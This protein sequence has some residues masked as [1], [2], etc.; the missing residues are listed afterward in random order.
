M[1]RHAITVD[2]EDWYQSTIDARADL[3]D[4]FR[5]STDKV[6]ESFAARGVRGTFFCLGLAAQ[7]APAVIRAI[8]DAGHEVQSHG[9]GHVEV[10]KLTEDQFRQDL[11]RARKLLED[12]IGAKVYGY[13]AP[14]FSIDERT[15]WAH[16]VLA[17]THHRY[18]S[19]I[20]PIKMPRYGVDGY[21]PQPRIIQTSRGHRIIE[22]PIACFDW[23]GKRRPVGGGGYFRLLP[24]WV[25]RKA[26]RQMDR[27]GRCGVAYMH[28]Y[29]YDP[30]EMGDYRKSV[31]LKQRLHQSIGRKG[32]PGKVDRL[33]R[34]FKFGALDEAIADLLAQL[35]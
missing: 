9:Y 5:A 32:F 26:W 11:D 4:R 22:A 8:A 35:P 19:S 3:S 23:L 33:L 14:S 6:L 25:L 1:V 10:F 30:G 2:V 13:R 18:S 21:P 17:E 20:F 24:Y 27:L 31:S 28:P 12:M 7:K 16:D 29:E 15:P 34:D